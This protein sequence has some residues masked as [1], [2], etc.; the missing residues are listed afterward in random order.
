MLSHSLVRVT[1]QNAN[2]SIYHSLPISVANII[3]IE[4]T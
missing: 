4:M 3:G 1:V 2:P